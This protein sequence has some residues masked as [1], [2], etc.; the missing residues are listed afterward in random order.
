MTSRRITL[1]M[2]DEDGSHIATERVWCSEQTPPADLNIYFGNAVR[3]LVAKMTNHCLPAGY[4]KE[5]DSV[6]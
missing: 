4:A 3:G 6:G 1:S 2:V 5:S